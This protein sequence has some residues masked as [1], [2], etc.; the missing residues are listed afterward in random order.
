MQADLARFYRQAKPEE[1]AFYT[2]V[3]Y[4][5]QD[6]VFRVATVYGNAIYLTGGTALARFHFRHRLSEDLDFFTTTDD[7]K[8]IVADMMARLSNQGYA[9]EVERLELYFARCYVALDDVRLKIDFAR[10]FNLLGALEQTQS[11]IFVNPLEDIG[12][13]KIS[14]FE[15]RAEMK[16]IVDLYYICRTCSLD[17][18]FELTDRKRAPVPYESLLTINT[19]GVSG[20]VLTTQ[21]LAEQELTRFLDELRQ[22]TEEE[23]KKKELWAGEHLEQVIN[24]LL[25]DFPPEERTLSAAARPV[26]RRRLR[27][28]PLPARR[29]LARVVD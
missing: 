9:V 26:L 10:E 15:D 25:W 11:G 19:I 18:L 29:A 4:P 20:R 1:L 28:L 8:L 6:R 22:R 21:P 16:D 5:L 17:R 14:A 2:E 23:V 13:N 24:R 12:A 27:T 7:L 3:L